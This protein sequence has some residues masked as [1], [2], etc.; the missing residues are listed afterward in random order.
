MHGV[1]QFPRQMCVLEDLKNNSMLLVVNTHL[2]FH[3]RGSHV[4]L[5]Q[6]QILLTEMEG[7]VE[8]MR[9]E[10]PGRTISYLFCADM[11]S[12]PSS[13]AIELIKSGKLAG[14]HTDWYSCKCVCFVILLH[15]IKCARFDWRIFVRESGVSTRVMNVCVSALTFESECSAFI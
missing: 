5:A 11:N 2:Y 14:N 8:E 9:K 6:T 4:R 10:Y 1:H 13:G 12:Y 15:N 7:V 3:P